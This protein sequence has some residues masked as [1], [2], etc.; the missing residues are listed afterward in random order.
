MEPPYS[1]PL[2][3]I[4]HDCRLACSMQFRAGHHVRIRLV[5]VVIAA[6][7]VPQIDALSSMRI[8]RCSKVLAA[9][10]SWLCRPHVWG[11]HLGGVHLWGTR[12]KCPISTEVLVG[13][14]HR[15][16]LPSAPLFLHW[17]TILDSACAGPC[18]IGPE[19]FTMMGT[20]VLW[21]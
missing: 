19:A 3:C 18:M 12:S 6:V 15:Q 1:Y 9:L 16:R 4:M 11:A 13:N 21:R 7:E 2:A 14:D 10:G 8:L 20:W 17:P 5:V